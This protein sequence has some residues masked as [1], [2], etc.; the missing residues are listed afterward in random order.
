MTTYPGTGVPRDSH[1]R[2]LADTYYGMLPSN[3]LSPSSADIRASSIPSKRFQK[4]KAYLSSKHRDAIARSPQPIII[5]RGEGYQYNTA[6]TKASDRKFGRMDLRK[7]A[8][9]E[10]HQSTCLNLNSANDVDAD[11]DLWI[12]PSLEEWEM[13][14]DSC[15]Q[16]SLKHCGDGVGDGAEWAPLVSRAVTSNRE[17]LRRRLE[18]D[19]WDF[20]CGKYGEDGE[21]VY[22]YSA[23]QHQQPHHEDDSGSGEESVDEEFDVVV[24]TIDAVS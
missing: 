4:A 7:E 10:L 5:S 18:G 1:L 13:D 24:L 8:H 17:R 21:E 23:F 3:A 16:L 19:G 12:L 14:A 20:V 6:A 11:S 9:I 22:S 2:D 15:A